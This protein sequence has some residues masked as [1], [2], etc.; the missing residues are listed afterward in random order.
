MC[1]YYSQGC[2]D[3]Q[4]SLCVFIRPKYAQEAADGLAPQ[5]WEG[6]VHHWPDELW[7]G[8]MVSACANAAVDNEKSWVESGAEAPLPKNR[9]WPGDAG[10]TAAYLA[11]FCLLSRRRRR[12]KTREEDMRGFA[13]LFPA[14]PTPTVNSRNGFLKVWKHWLDTF[15]HH[16]WNW[17]ETW[18]KLKGRSWTHTFSFIRQKCF[19]P[20][21]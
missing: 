13:V 1:V 16:T 15:K 9:A 8:V 10:H 2:A 3:I 20:R 19:V 7:A 21:W 12:K 17:D 6:D 11:Y 5:A 14:V 18:R 4:A